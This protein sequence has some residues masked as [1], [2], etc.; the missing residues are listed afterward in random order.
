MYGAMTTDNPG[1]APEGVDPST[2]P[3]GNQGS[4][5]GTGHSGVPETEG[6]SGRIGTTT[7]VAI[8]AVAVLATAVAV[9]F[10]VGASIGIVRIWT[11][12]RLMIVVIA[13]IGL[14]F[15]GSAAWL[16][17]LGVAA[18]A[19]TRVKPPG[20]EQGVED[21]ASRAVDGLASFFTS[22]GPSGRLAIGGSLHLWIAGVLA[23][24]DLI[25]SGG[26]P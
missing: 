10:L 3:A 24:V 15:L 2:P 4:T 12:L 8:A 19:Q 23:A 14:L 9:L 1:D 5:P 22:T 25:N 18:A 26:R 6:D 17:G 20:M 7:A 11:L 21:L 13:V 16:A